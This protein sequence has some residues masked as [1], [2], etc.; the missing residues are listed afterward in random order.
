MALRS[1]VGGRRSPALTGKLAGG[2][3]TLAPAAGGA[4]MVPAASAGV[5]G[6]EMIFVPSH[7]PAPGWDTSPQHPNGALFQVA[8]SGQ[9]GSW[10]VDCSQSWEV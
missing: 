4:L 3:R 6:R 7:L 8:A 10:K 5:P 9:C 2:K 1:V